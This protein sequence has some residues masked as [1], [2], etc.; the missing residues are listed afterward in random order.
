MLTTESKLDE[1]QLPIFVILGS[2]ETT[3]RR[4]DHS[5]EELRDTGRDDDTAPH[6]NSEVGE[7]SASFFKIFGLR[8]QSR[9]LCHDSL[10][11][12]FCASSPSYDADR[13]SFLTAKSNR[14]NTRKSLGSS[15]PVLDGFFDTP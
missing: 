11:S 12:Q 5:A 7:N 4:G 2:A 1:T 15:H 9:D 3:V 10:T 8:V 14:Q 6:T 13:G